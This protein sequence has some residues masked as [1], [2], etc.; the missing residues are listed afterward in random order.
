ME[1]LT[2]TAAISA[3]VGYLANT[4]AE[5]KTFKDFTKDFSTATVEWIK[6]LFL[7]EDDEPKQ[8][9]QSLEK[10]PDSTARK[11]GVEAALEIAVEDNPQLASYLQALAKEILEKEK[12]EKS[13][14]ITNSKNVVMGNIQAGGNVSIGDTS[15]VQ[16]HYGSGDNVGGN[17]IIRQ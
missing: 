5:N 1:P 16:N 2:T 8:V 15:T 11:K 4:F 9:I 3:V 10:K 6:P 7:K 14:N 12:S 13:I 17:K